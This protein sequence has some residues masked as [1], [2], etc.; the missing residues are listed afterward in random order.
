MTVAQDGHIGK[1]E[2]HILHGIIV[3]GCR[4]VLSILTETESKNMR[5]LK[6]YLQQIRFLFF[7]NQ[8][9]SIARIVL[10]FVLQGCVFY[11]NKI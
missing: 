3:L 1:P 5:Q 11:Y 6:L 10:L 8:T 9:E 2:F 4:V 7:C